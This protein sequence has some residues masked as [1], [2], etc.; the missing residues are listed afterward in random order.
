[1]VD[2]PLG[3]QRPAT[4]HDADEPLADKFE[5]AHQNAGMRHAIAGTGIL[6]LLASLLGAPI[7]LLAGIFLSEYSSKSKLAAPV[8]FTADV[9]MGVPSIVVGILGYE[10]LVVPLGHYNGYA[11]ALAL[12]FIMSV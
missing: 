9:L 8:R 5:M 7:G 10:L 3:Q 4:A 11:G 1:M 12:G 2:H 6:I